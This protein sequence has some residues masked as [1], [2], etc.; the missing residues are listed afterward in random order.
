MAP[1][2]WYG[3]KGN[4]V[5][6]IASLI[7]DGTVY[8]EPYCGAASIFWSIKPRPVEVL[9]DLNGEVIGL[10]RCLQDQAQ[11]ERLAHRIA[12][13]PYSLDEFRLALSVLKSDESDA[14]TRAWAFFVAHGQGFSGVART[15]GNWGKAFISGRGM[16][17]TTNAWRGRLKTLQVWHDRLTR[18]QLDNR[19]ALEVIRYWDS[20]DTAFYIDPPYVK[21][22]R[23]RGKRS[24]YTCEADDEHHSALVQTLLGIKGAAALSGYDT[25]I[26]KPLT[27]AGW[28]VHRF[29]TACHAAS[30]ARNSPVR[31]EGSAI[32]R[33]PRTE[34]VWRSPS[35]RGGLFHN[36]VTE[37]TE[38]AQEE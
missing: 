1:M 22:S 9:N 30:R 8:C 18:V 17:R 25:P 15:E 4:M 38:S 37:E 13:T 6:K 27:E 19:D 32:K 7:P 21:E 36:T 2:Q 35:C 26:Y 31:G 23:V 24:V 16:A 5:S 14:V 28:T 12:F 10:F 29:D 11:F 3:G 33:C 34:V 20:P